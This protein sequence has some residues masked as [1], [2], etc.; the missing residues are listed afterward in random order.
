M[1]FLVAPNTDEYMDRNSLWGLVWALRAAGH[2]AL[3]PARPLD[4]FETAPICRE[5]KVDVL[6]QLNRGR[7]YDLPKHIRH[8]A[9]FQDQ[10]H[11]PRDLADRV[12]P[13][14]LVYRVVPRADY[15]PDV[16]G[17]CFSGYLLLAM[18]ESMLDAYVPPSEKSVDF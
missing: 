12:Q 1:R 11:I 5:L 4:G 9:W 7:P 8:I 14:D 13:T 10:P 18:D 2:E 17:R 16:N 6:F 3:F 15:E